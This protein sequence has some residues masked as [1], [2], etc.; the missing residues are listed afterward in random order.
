MPS[1]LVSVWLI[2]EPDPAE[3]PSMF[4]APDNVHEY[5]VP[6]TPFVL[7]MTILVVSPLQM[8]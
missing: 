7:L 8:F 4:E 1:A 3:A 6:A 2:T 5:V